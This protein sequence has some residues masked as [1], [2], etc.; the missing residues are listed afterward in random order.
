M[1]LWLGVDVGGE[2]KGF[3]VALINGRRLLA[4]ESRLDRTS[5]AELVDR[6]R[7]AVVAIDGPRCCAQPGRTSRDCERELVRSIC[8]IR[9]T[10]D[11][12]AV[13]ASE[14]YA[15]VAQGLAL[16]DAL[17]GCGAEVIEVFPTAS[18]TRWLGKRGSRTRIAWTRDGLSV[19]DL[20][21]LPRRTNQDQR[22]AIAAA[23][24][25][26]LHDRGLTEAIGEI[27]VPVRGQDAVR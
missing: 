9:W 20:G 3:D 25:A 19:L 26:R 11:E 6:A 5:V 23:A 16:F 22:D 27:V 13:H 4:L 18:W 8:G 1:D 24:T 17:A 10:P 14:Y 7:P 2:R 15:W 21:D 12:R